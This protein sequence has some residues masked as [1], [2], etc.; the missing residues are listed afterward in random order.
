MYQGFGSDLFDLSMIDGGKLE[1]APGI[2]DVPGL[3]NDTMQLSLS[4]FENK[5]IEFLLSIDEGTP[6]DLYGDELRIKQILCNILTSAYE[7]TDRGRVEISVKAEIGPAADGGEAGARRKCVLI[8]R[9]SDTGRGLSEEQI[10]KLFDEYTRF[11]YDGSRAALDRGLGMSV[12]K[13]LID[14]MNGEITLEN[15]PGKGSGFTLRIPQEFIGDAK[16]KPEMAE[17]I[18]SRRFQGMHCSNIAPS[19]AEYMPYG[20]VLIVDDF[21]SSRSAARNLMLTYGLNIDTASSGSEAVEKIRKGAVYDIV[22]MDYMMPKMDGLETTRKIRDLGYTHPVVALTAYVVKGQEELLLA[23]GCDE[24]IYKP[25]KA[26]ELDAVLNRL[27]RDKQAQDVIDEARREKEKRVAA[28]DLSFSPAPGFREELLT[29]TLRDAENAI[30]VLEE[31]LKKTDAPGGADVE[32]FITTVHGLKSALSNV[33]E[34]ELS[35]AARNLEKSGADRSGNE[36]LE[37]TPPFIESIRAFIEK[38]RETETEEATEISNEDAIFLRERI[39]EIKEACSMLDIKAAR[40][41][42]ADLRKKSWPPY[43]R[44]ILD[45]LSINLIRGDFRKVASDAEATVAALGG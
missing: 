34:I 33:G 9:I 35:N 8:F 10:S 29:V 40:A 17:E 39:N 30:R 4:G 23:S 42:M 41:A 13:R 18:R 7:Y 28:G 14:A 20:Q 6:H 21:E 5:P 38:S 25:I 19:D 1:L 26:H 43:I 27:I 3:I 24:H 12:T 16:C 36:I 45:E 15:R 31:I 11:D 22:F 32:L 44:D 37:K 2:Y